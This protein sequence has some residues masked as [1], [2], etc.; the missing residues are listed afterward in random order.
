[1]QCIDLD[2]WEVVDLSPMRISRGRIT[3]VY[4]NDQIYVSSPDGSGGNTFERYYY[5]GIHSQTNIADDV[6]LS[7]QIRYPVGRMA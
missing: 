1:M 7:F 5:W 2:S 4:L 3:A 6:I